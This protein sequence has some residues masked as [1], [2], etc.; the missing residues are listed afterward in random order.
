MHTEENIIKKFHPH[1]LLFLGFY[2]G[3]F[4]LA[5]VG[6]AIS[7][8]LAS[9]GILVIVLGEISRLAETFYITDGGVVQEYKFL[10]TH[11]KFAE[12]R[13]IQNIEVR[14]SFLENIFGIGNIYFDT[15]GADKT[16]VN[17]RGVN[18]PYKIEKIV[19]EK[20]TLAG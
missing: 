18:H 15:A 9:I 14:Q 2:L 11:R 12:Y 17:F 20:M 13:R 10:T 3:G 5:L 7:K 1:P 4:I 6:F 8:P 16:E 19:R